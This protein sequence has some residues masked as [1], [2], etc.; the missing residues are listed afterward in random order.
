M[1]GAQRIGRKGQPGFA[2]VNGIPAQEF[3]R[4]QTDV[5]SPLPKR[6]HLDDN[7]GQPKIK[8]LPKLATRNRL[9]QIHSD[10]RVIAATNVNLQESVAITRVSL[11]LLAAAHSLKAL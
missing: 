2:V 4:H 1:D 9:L 3:L 6:G 8:I 11:N 7:D 5:V 10:T